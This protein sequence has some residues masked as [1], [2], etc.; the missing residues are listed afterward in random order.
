MNE[1]K[2]EP[3]IFEDVCKMVAGTSILS[4][5]RCYK[6]EVKR[7]LEVMPL[8]QYPEEQVASF[9]R[10]VFGNTEENG[11]A[12]DERKQMLKKLLLEFGIHTR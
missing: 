6:D 8:D 12:P 1:E 4:D 5:L 3:D 7:I 2:K 11:K 9:R 10:Y